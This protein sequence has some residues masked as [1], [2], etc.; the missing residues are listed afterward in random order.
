MLYACIRL[1]QRYDGRTTT[2]Y[3]YH[4]K[5]RPTATVNLVNFLRKLLTDT[6]NSSE[7]IHVREYGKMRV[8]VLPH[9]T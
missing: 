1:V 8:V 6:H 5:I 7:Y 2:S 9:Q 3:T 4:R